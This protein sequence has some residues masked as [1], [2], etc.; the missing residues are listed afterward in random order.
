M[1]VVAPERGRLPAGSAVRLEEAIARIHRRHGAMALRRGGDPLP[2]TVWPSGIPTLDALTGIGGLPRGRLSV[3]A[4]MGAGATGRLTLLQ[5]LTSAASREGQAA[6]LDLAGSLDPGFLADLGADLDACLVLRPPGDAIAAGLAMARALLRA[7]VPWLGVALGRPVRGRPRRPADAAEHALTALVGTLEGA[8][9][10]ACVAAPA[11]LPATLAHA[12]SLTLD[13]GP[14]GW[15]MAHGDVA[16][17]RLRLHL[18]KSKL[19]APGAEAG[20]LVRYPRPWAAAEVV[21]LP[22]VVDG[23]ATE[24]EADAVAAARTG[25][26][27]VEGEGLGWADAAPALGGTLPRR[28]G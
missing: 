12:S 5:A 7:G 13:C 16:G 23:A 21:G 11:P 28:Q 18:A 10:V 20:L 1:A 8:R 6:Y 2:G 15:D 27:D 22:A 17:L 14:A 4:G 3:L 24:P 25:R 19:G 26:L 9:A